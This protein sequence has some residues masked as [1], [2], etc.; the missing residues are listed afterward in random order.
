MYII[1]LNFKNL[2]NSSISCENIVKG[3]SRLTTI[4]FSGKTQKENAKKIITI[5]NDMLSEN[6]I[7]TFN[8]EIVNINNYQSVQDEEILVNLIAS[9][10][11]FE[12]FASFVDLNLLNNST[13][14]TNKIIGGMA[15]VYVTL[16]R[17]NK[18]VIEDIPVIIRPQVEAMLKEFK[19]VE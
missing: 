15:E 18:K 6:S 8:N 2:S 13:L 10:N 7:S 19:G 5:F 12:M 1:S 11:L 14:K 16:I 17:K 9:T 4:G 3:C